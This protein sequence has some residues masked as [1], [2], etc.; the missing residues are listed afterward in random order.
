MKTMQNR[1]LLQSTEQKLESFF[2]FCFDAENSL[3][4]PLP[5]ESSRSTV[6]RA[7]IRAEV[8]QRQIPEDGVPVSCKDGEKAE[9]ELYPK[10]CLLGEE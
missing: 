5:G 10:H 8:K 1:S 6:I 3:D 4:G 9:E 2:L 7:E